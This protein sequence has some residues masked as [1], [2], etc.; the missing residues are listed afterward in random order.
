MY[1]HET[2]NTVNTVNRTL[3]GILVMSEK[4]IFMAP[5]ASTMQQIARFQV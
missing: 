4:V 5:N 2:Q 1:L 3:Q